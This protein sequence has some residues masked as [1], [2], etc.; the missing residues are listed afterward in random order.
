ML[1]KE[2]FITIET[3]IKIST[4]KGKNRK[5]NQ[6][7]ENDKKTKELI[8]HMLKLLMLNSAVVILSMVN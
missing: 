5:T 1:F 6:M 8:I 4:S 7:A 3:L 2:C